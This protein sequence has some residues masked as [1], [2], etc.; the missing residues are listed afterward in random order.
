MAWLRL[1]VGTTRDAVDWVCC[2]LAACG[3]D[4]E[5]EISEAENGAASWPL[6]VRLHLPAEGRL[7]R[8]ELDEALAP[9]RRLG[10]A[11]DLAIEA[12]AAPVVAAAP[13]PAP[14]R[15][16]TR[17]VLLAHDGGRAPDEG[18]VAVRIAPGTAFGSGFHPTTLVSLALIERHV[19]PGMAVLDLGSGSG[20]LSV[21]SAGLGGRVLAVDNDPSAVAATRQAVRRNGLEP[22]V[23][24]ARGSLGRGG[25]LGHW[26]GWRRLD[27][28]P[29]V[30]ARGGFDLIASNILARVHVELADDYRCALRPAGVLITAGFTVAQ[31]PE[32]ALALVAAGLAPRDREQIDEYV[33]LAHHAVGDGPSGAPSG[34]DARPR[35]DEPGQVGPKN[36]DGEAAPG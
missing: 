12:V 7:S 9:L 6:T 10:L 3:Y 15:V 25:R 17:L 29:S 33:A 27:E 22:R 24:V 35:R 31:E 14:R 13:G 32:V 18:D 26:L 2:A 30:E 23:T 16:G 36:G 1:G 28:A 20:I 8:A 19:S 34:R 11:G 5:V 21:A 4:G